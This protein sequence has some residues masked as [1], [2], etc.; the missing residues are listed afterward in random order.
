[1]D[2]SYMLCGCLSVF[3]LQP[4]LEIWFTQTLFQAPLQVFR[5][6]V[7]RKHKLLARPVV[8]LLLSK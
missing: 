8:I 4:L 2:A 6:D 5:C 7:C 1:M 3:S